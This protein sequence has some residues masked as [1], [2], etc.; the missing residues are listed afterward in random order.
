MSVEG[1][2]LLLVWQLLWLGRTYFEEACRFSSLCASNAHYNW[3]FNSQAFGSDRI[4]P[5]KFH[6]ISAIA[7]IDNSYFEAERVI[8]AEH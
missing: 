8:V 1:S 5:A 2:M 4:V 6:M 7:Y 3:L